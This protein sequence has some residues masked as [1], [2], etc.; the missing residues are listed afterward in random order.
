VSDSKQVFIFGYSGHSYVILDSLLDAGY[1]ISGYFDCSKASKNPFNLE[2]LGFEGK[3]NVSDIVRQNF[4]FPTIGENSIRKKLIDLFERNH[5]KQFVA[6]DPSA[7]VSGSVKIGVSS[8]IG[9]NACVNALSA[10][11]KGA[12]INTSCVV[13]HECEIGDYSHIGPGSILCGNVKI[14]SNAFIGANSVVKQNISIGPDIL[15]GAGSTVVK[16]IDS[17]TVYFGNPAKSK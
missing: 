14:G 16:S 9:K 8:Y 6:V 3:E 10:I 12:I 15:I 5:L 2:Y 17:G 7:N 4:V 1:Q 11:G 13:E